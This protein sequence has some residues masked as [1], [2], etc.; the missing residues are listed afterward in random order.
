MILVLGGT[1][2]TGRL[3]AAALTRHGHPVRT[4]SRQESAATVRFDWY[5][6]ATHPDALAGTR[7][8]YLLPP[9]GEVDPAPVMLP[10]LAL[11]G[12][13]GVR[14]AVLLSSSAI[15]AGPHGAGLVHARLPGLFPEWAVLR[16]SWFMENFVGDHPH[17]VSARRHGEIVSATGDGRVGFVDPADI[18]EVAARALTDPTPHNTEHLITGPETLSYADVASVLT[19]LGGRAVR[20]RAVGPAEMTDHLVAGGIPRNF[21]GL[22]AG[23]DAAI[24]AGAEDRTTTTVA[25]VTGRA[26]RTFRDFCAGRLGGTA[27]AGPHTPAT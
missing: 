2:T 26:P 4:A 23:L 9:V 5:D 21:A 7:A 8:V 14:R 11:A 15:P 1:G 13:L 18:A 22:L 20:H 12:R 19:D 25:D 16:P 27:P 10:F 6:P 17:A 24:A 3:L